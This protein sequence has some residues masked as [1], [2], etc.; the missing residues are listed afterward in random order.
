MVPAGRQKDAPFLNLFLPTRATPAD[1]CGVFL[2][3]TFRQLKK[4]FATRR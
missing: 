1:R 2:S 4:A 3:M